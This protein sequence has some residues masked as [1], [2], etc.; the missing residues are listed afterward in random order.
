ME[1]QLNLLREK[2]EKILEEVKDL[3]SLQDLKVKILGRKGEL[4]LILRQ[5]G[6]IPPEDRPRLGMMSNEVKRH[7]QSLMELKEEELKKAS[8]E[9]QLIKEKVDVTFPGII[10]EVGHI[11]PIRK[12]I[13]RIKEIFIGMGFSVR[14]GP[15]VETD[16]YNFEALNIPAQHASRDMW[17]SFYLG[18]DLLLRSHTSPVQVRV[19]EKEEPPLRIISLGKCFRRDTV[20]ASHY[21]TFYQAEG[22]MVDE[23]VT[24]G[25]LKGVLLNFTREMF[26]K[27]RKIKFIPSY[28]PFTEPSAEI[29]VDCFICKGKGCRSCGGGGW[30]EILGAGMINPVVYKW[31]DS[32]REK[33]SYDPEKYSGFAFGMG[34]ERIAMLAYGIEDIRLFFENDLKFLKQF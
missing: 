1:E 5:L 33:P 26:G 19:M 20:D 13:R 30:L 32:L 17:D 24:F 27:D 34:I 22:F 7:L 21:W 28:F 18:K 31:A 14:E 6:Q 4:T 11:H 3:E 8:L 16:Y 15:E 29:C 12:V 2:T 23:D 10:P 25:D 9:S